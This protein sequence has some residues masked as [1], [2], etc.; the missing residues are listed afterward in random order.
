MPVYHAGTGKGYDFELTLVLLIAF[1][2]LLS[3]LTWGIP[4]FRGI[5]RRRREERLPADVQEE[6]AIG[7]TDDLGHWHS[8]SVE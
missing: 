8:A 3:L 7:T 6:E 1:F 2:A 5:L 4:W